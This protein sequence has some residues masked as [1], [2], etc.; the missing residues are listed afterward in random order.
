MTD[1]ALTLMQWL[2]PAFPVGA[3]AY[4]HGLE[5]AIADGQVSDAATLQDWIETLITQGSACADAILLAAAYTADDPAQIDAT[6]RAFAASAERLKEADLQGT[7][8]CDT[9]RAVWNIDISTLTYPVAVGT[10]AR[11][12]AVPLD[13][14]LPLYLHAFA[15]NL[16]A[17]AQRLMALGQTTGQQV[18]ANLAPAITATATEATTSSLDDLTATSFAADIAAMRHEALSP[19]IFRT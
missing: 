9:A 10:A 3:F 16:I 15:S 14:T 8:F 5:Q 12:M 19:R 1:P 6:A 2:S 4:S 18:L 11:A 7:A 17:A 13:Q